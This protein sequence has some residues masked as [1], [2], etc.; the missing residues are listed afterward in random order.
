M[1][2]ERKAFLGRKSPQV[3]AGSWCFIAS[4]EQEDLK[5]D[6][7]FNAFLLL[8]TGVNRSTGLWNGP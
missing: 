8:G 1:P 2:R 6:F 5:T 3:R 7:S 4:L